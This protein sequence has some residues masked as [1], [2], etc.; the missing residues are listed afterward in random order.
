[1]LCK[2]V[3]EKYG[4]M[5]PYPISPEKIAAAGYDV[6]KYIKDM[7][8]EL[9]RCDDVGDEPLALWV[10]RMVNDLRKDL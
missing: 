9:S 3:L 10:C 6:D 8:E 5:V 1:M 7:G 2:E 4:K